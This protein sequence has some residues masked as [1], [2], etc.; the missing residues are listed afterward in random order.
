MSTTKYAEDVQNQLN[1]AFYVQEDTGRLLS[2][3]LS[4]RRT[5]GGDSAGLAC[6][7]FAREFTD[8]YTS[9]RCSASEE[10]F[11]KTVLLQGQVI[12]PSGH[13]NKVLVPGFTRVSSGAMWTFG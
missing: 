8:F 6:I 4:D 7:R 13:R 9:V 1:E 12:P 10:A 3:V 11:S 2:G 5:Q